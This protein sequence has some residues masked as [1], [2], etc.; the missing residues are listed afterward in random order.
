ME[1]GQVHLRRSEGQRL[2]TVLHVYTNI[3]NIGNDIFIKNAEVA[4]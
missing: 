2:Y 3:S 4:L 1:C